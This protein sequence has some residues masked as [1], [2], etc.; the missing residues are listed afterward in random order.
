MM[1]KPVR[2]KVPKK[3][4]RKVAR[5]S[6]TT[7][8]MSKKSVS[9]KAPTPIAES[10][11]NKK[12]S[13]NLLIVGVVLFLM[14]VGVSVAIG[15][16]DKGSIAVSETIRERKEN[17][18]P[19][20]LKEMEQIDTKVRKQVPRGGLTPTGDTQKPKPKPTP[21]SEPE[22]VASST[23]PTVVDEEESVIDGTTQADATEEVVPTEEVVESGE[24]V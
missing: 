1:D 18:T 20:E 3:A 9:R 14:V 4:A 23:E 13:R 17:A 2:K 11:A 7:K 19:D 6:T 12:H 21:A 22:N 24:G 5:K 10:R 16:S 15:F 8:T